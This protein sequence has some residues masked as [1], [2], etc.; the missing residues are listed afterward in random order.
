VD[1]RN[2]QIARQQLNGMLIS[3]SRKVV[4]DIAPA[5]QRAIQ[6]YR[7]VQKYRAYAELSE[8]ELS[9]LVTRLDPKQMNAYVKET[10]KVDEAVDKA[11]MT[12]ASAI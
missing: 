12:G 11:M 9:H 10:M 6:K 4:G 3:Q 8:A 1:I 2:A 5:T 7:E